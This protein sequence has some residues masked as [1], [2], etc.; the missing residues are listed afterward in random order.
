MAGSCTWCEVSPGDHELRS[1]VRL[2]VQTKRLELG[3]ERVDNREV[4]RN[5]VG[6]RGW[7]R[8]GMMKPKRLFRPAG[9]PVSGVGG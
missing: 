6:G 3:Q 9:L 2:E 1:D 8:W 5:T 4:G 7:G